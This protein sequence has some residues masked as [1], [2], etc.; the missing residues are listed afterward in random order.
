MSIDVLNAYSIRLADREKSLLLLY[1]MGITDLAVNSDLLLRD[2]DR[3][4]CVILGI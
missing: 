3:R 4:A 2:L 1:D